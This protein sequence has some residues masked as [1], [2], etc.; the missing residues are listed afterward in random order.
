[1]KKF[2][3]LT[4]AAVVLTSTSVFASRPR[5]V[6]ASYH[7]QLGLNTEPG[8]LEKWCALPN[9]SF[10]EQGGIAGWT[11][12]SCNGC[13]IGASWNPTKDTD[14]TYCHQSARPVKGSADIPTVAKCMTCHIKDTSKRGDLFTASTDVHIAAGMLCQDCH[15]RT[16]DKRRASDHQFLKGTA[17]DTTEP[18]MEGTVDCAACHTS[19]PHGKGVK[20]YARINRHLAKVACETCH[21]GQRPAGALLSRR[22]D[23]FSSGKPVTTKRPPGWMPEYKWYDNT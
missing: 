8:M 23:K 17:I 16:S 14:C 2:L 20:R 4:L 6:E 18:T 13:H 22:W 3:V 9:F 7:G 21:T 11:S 15:V 10:D 12:M 19:K 1:M 5:G